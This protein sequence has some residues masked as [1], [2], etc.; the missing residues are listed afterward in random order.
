MALPLKSATLHRLAIAGMLVAITA[1]ILSGLVKAV[2]SAREPARW[3]SCISHLKILGLALLSYE[4]DN[5]SFPPAYIADRNG[6]PLHSWRVLILPYLDR[7]D[8][9]EKYRFD[10]PW[11]GVHNR[12]LA[13]LIPKEFQCPTDHAPGSET[14]DYLAVVGP[15]TVWPEGNGLRLSD[16]GTRGT[17]LLV[18]VADS[19]VSWLE[20]RDLSFDDATVGVNKGRGIRSCHSGG[21][22]C[23]FADGHVDTL[24]NN[25]SPRLL[26][27]LLRVDVADKGIDVD[28]CR[29]PIG[30]SSS[31]P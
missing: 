28:N 27:N 24:S 13:Q 21:A 17:I 11:N 29:R 25:I 16:F 4:K 10:E 3:C 26:S 30:Q 14:T 1:V 12:R 18:E 9:Y 8:L 22:S 6:K 15:N 5:G 2:Q 7:K 23:L 31:D 19:G 20:P